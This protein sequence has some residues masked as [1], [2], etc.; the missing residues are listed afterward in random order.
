MAPAA[1]HGKPRWSRLCGLFAE[2]AERRYACPSLQLLAAGLLRGFVWGAAGAM[3]RRA[4]V[5]ARPAPGAAERVGRR[6]GRRAGGQAGRQ[7]D[8]TLLAPDTRQSCDLRPTR[9][10]AWAFVSTAAAQETEYRG[11]TDP[12]QRHK[13]PSTGAEETH[14]RG[15]RHLIQRHKRPHT[16][17]EDEVRARWL[18]P[19]RVPQR[20]F[21]R[22]S[23]PESEV[24]AQTCTRP[25]RGM[26]TV[27]VDVGRKYIYIYM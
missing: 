5:S 3:R 12:V 27:D 9:C 23:S 6:V 14:Y 22:T 4:A 18:L 15:K 8:A 16:D 2:Q 11:K 1:P 25:T 26:H 19:L 7:G 13:R 10:V 21:A 20:K 24:P 17:L